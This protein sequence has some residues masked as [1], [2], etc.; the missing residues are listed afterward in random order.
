MA[1]KNGQISAHFAILKVGFW[2]EKVGFGQIWV[3]FLVASKPDTGNFG[4]ISAHFAHFFSKVTRHFGHKKP[5]I[6]AGFRAK[7]PLSHFF[8][9]TKYD[10]KI[11]IYNK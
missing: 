4:Q 10:K 9:Q 11:N 2:S 3:E 6:Y 8:H 1:R 5:S 7:S